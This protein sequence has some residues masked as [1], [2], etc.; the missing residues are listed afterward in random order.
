MVVELDRTADDSRVRG[1]GP[2]V[3]PKGRLSLLQPVLPYEPRFLLPAYVR[4]L[5]YLWLRRGSD[6]TAEFRKIVLNKRRF[7]DAKRLR[8]INSA[9][10]RSRFF[11][12][13]PRPSE[14][15]YVHLH[16]SR[17]D[18]AKGSFLREHLECHP[19]EPENLQVFQTRLSP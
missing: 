3:D 8:K 4:G 18:G 14:I 5:A 12:N 17:A 19:T 9:S 11:K 6:D 1:I 2:P 16:T 7:L 15:L 10:I 13:S